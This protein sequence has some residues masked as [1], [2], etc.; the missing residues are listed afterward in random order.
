LEAN[1]DV[2]PFEEVA[3][4]LLHFLF[5]AHVLCEKGE[6]KDE[7]HRHQAEADEDFKEDKRLLRKAQCLVHNQT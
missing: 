4:G 1:L 6:E 5:H 3:A 2:L 7:E